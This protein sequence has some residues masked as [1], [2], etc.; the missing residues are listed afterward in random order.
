M[1]TIVMTKLDGKLDGSIKAKAMSFL[2]KLGTDDTTPGLHIE[3][4]HASIDPRVRTG[5]VDQ[6]WRAVLFRLDKDSEAYYV[7]H[8][9]WPHDKANKIA[10]RLTLK[11]NPVNGLP[12]FE[13][14]PEPAEPAPTLVSPPVQKSLAAPETAPLLVEQGRTRD[15]L[16]NT[17]GLPEPIADE[18]LSC[19]GEDEVWA[20]A[21]R[22]ER[23]WVSEILLA[24]AV[25]QPVA[26]I[27]QE[28]ELSRPE[29]TGSDT[30]VIASLQQPAAR[31]QFAIIEGQDEL[32]RVIEGGDFEAWRVFLHPEQRR[33]VEQNSNGPFRLSGG[34]G[35]GKTVVLVH[36]ARRLARDDPA[37]RVVV[38]TYTT[39]L[40]GSLREMLRRLDPALPLA[41]TPGGPGTYVA[42]IDALISSV[43]KSADI[44]GLDTAT[45]SVLGETRS[46]PATRTPPGRWASVLESTS[47]DLPS[48]IANETF[49]ATE[50]ALIVLP[51]KVQT[52][53]EFLRV[54]RPGRGVALD[55]S[56]RSAVWALIKA[57]RAQG[58]VD[59]SLDFAEAAAVAAAHLA[60][61]PQD[62]PAD[63]A[64]VDEAQDLTPSQFEFL[65]ALVPEQK[66]DLFIA[67][68]SHQRIYGPRVVL[69]RYGI[70]IRGRSRRLRLNYRTTAQNLRWAMSILDGGDYVDLEDQPEATG[71]RSARSGPEPTVVS[72]A[73]LEAELGEIV[74]R[75]REWLNQDVD[76][77]TI[78]V[79]VHDRWQRDRVAKRLSES[80][81]KAF[82]VDRESPP[83][84][85]VLVMT[86]HR[87]KG[88][89]FSRV[90]LADVGYISSSERSRLD[91]MD[92]T[93]RADAELRRRS[94]DYVAATRARDE[95]VVLR[96][97]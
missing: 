27:V 19:P 43:I 48:E 21:Q 64:L 40:A 72:V 33:W 13:E 22:H 66:N 20:L 7:V 90:V 32:R 63:H 83:D 74:R 15:E 60:A 86:R 95:L 29:A 47:T 37:A 94:L 76:A 8:G 61:H 10:E 51:N 23:S 79:L 44:E 17:L 14:T 49:L 97:V 84:D 35:T 31:T 45:G 54:R 55:R 16:V 75:A 91:A 2:E 24:L 12:E 42:G 96:R 3:P 25:G 73:G 78:A 26:E 1:P 65:R 18:A 92:P 41:P 85:R 50:Y 57:Y 38:T 6:F 30:D 70:N 5:R 81:V 67:E 88:M 39:N 53:A 87:A 52:E 62:A 80:G 28:M 11:V 46:A 4:I 59:G 56:K 77:A 69:S 93:E 36:R 71:Y 58:A 9:I 82:A 68:D 89:E 34:A